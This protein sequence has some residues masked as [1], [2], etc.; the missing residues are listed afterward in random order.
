MLGKSVTCLSRSLSYV[1]LTQFVLSLNSIRLRF[2]SDREKQLLLTP[3]PEY[4]NSHLLLFAIEMDFEQLYRAQLVLQYSP[5][6]NGALAQA[7]SRPRGP[8]V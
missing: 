8:S 2:L 3:T 7:Q 4:L 1:G 5:A 6:S